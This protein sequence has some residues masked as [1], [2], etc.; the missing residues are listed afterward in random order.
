MTSICIDGFNLALANETG[1][2]TYEQNLLDSAVGFGF[3][4]LYSPA[5]W[6]RDDNLLSETA[7]VHANHPSLRLNRWQKLQQFTD[8]CTSRRS[9]TTHSML[10]LGE[11]ISDPARSAPG[12]KVQTRGP[13]DA[14]HGLLSEGRSVARLS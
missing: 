5:A 7:P 1:V 10:L 2:A 14:P 13:S 8:T 11:A 3:Q 12:Q 4:M 9:R 6:S